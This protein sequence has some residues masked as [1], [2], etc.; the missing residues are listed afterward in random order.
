M[1]TCS[2]CNSK[3][4]AKGLCKKHYTKTD[5]YK[6]L[7]KKSDSEFQ[8]RNAEKI[9]EVRKKRRTS[10]DYLESESYAKNLLAIEF[11]LSYKSLNENPLVV[12]SKQLSLKIKRTIKTKKN[13]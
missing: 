12:K 5:E 3:S 9:K 7:R 4:H 10:I 8:S 13:E 6:A 1:G 2:I 11:G